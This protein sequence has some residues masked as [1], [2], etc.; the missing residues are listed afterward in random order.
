LIAAVPESVKD[1]AT[2]AVWEQAL[3]DIAQGKAGLDEFLTKQ[4]VWLTALLV[5]IKAR[6]PE[7]ATGVAHAQSPSR[8]AA[9]KPQAPATAPS[10]ETLRC[11]KCKAGTLVQKTARK[12]SRAGQLFWACDGWPKCNFARR[13]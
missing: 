6:T 1:A 10:V 2:T 13:G 8:S 12:G 5:E 4:R 9:A 11:P 7:N 3:D